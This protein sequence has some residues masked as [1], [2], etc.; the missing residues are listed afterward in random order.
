M[1]EAFFSV[2]HSVFAQ[3]LTKPFSPVILQGPRAEKPDVQ[4]LGKIEAV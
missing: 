2:Y 1:G 3:F 4:S